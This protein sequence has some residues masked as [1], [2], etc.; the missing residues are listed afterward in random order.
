MGP[1]CHPLCTIKFLFLDYFWLLIF[2]HLPFSFDLMPPLKTLRN[3]LAHGTRMSSSM[4]YKSFFSWIFFT[5]WSLAI[6][7]FFS[8]PAALETLVSCWLVGPACHPLCTI[9]SLFLDFFYPLIFGHL[10]FSFDLMQPL[11]RWG[12]CWLMGPTCHPLYYKS[13]FSWIFF[14]LLFLAISFFFW[15]P[16]AL[17]TLSKLLTQGARMSSSMYNQLA[18]SWSERA[19]ISGTHMS[20]SMYNKSFF[21]WII[22][23]SWYLVSFLFLLI[24]CRLWNVE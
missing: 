14:T 16:A 15:S 18:R 19:C 3:L 11:K 17:E 8:S 22:F 13:L 4:Y 10:P 1:A 24:S 9:K 6:S 7:F 21:S 23:C 12:S 20:S 2:G 5:L